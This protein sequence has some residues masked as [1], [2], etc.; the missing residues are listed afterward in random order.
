MCA[1]GSAEFRQRAFREGCFVDLTWLL[2]NRSWV[3]EDVHPQ[4]T[5]VLT[6]LA[7]KT[8]EADQVIPMR[9]PYRSLE[10]YQG[11]VAN[12][13]LRFSVA[14][15]KSWTDTC[16]LPLL[17]TEDSGEVFLQLRKAPRLDAS[18][19]GSWRARP[20]AE[21]HATI[22]KPLM[23]LT[24]ESPGEGFWPVFKGESFDI[25]QP[26]TGQYYAWANAKKV[27]TAL[28]QKRKRSARLV[29]SPFYGFPEAWNKDPATL[30]CFAPRIAFRDVSRATDTRTVRAALLPAEVFLTNKAPYFVFGSGDEKDQAY[31]LAVLC[32]LPLDWYARRFVEINLNF[33]I[34][35]PFP[36]P[37]PE[38]SH[39][40][41]LRAVELGA[42]LGAPDRRFAK[43]ARTVG[44]AHGPLDEEQ[45]LAMIA[46]LDAVVAH[47]YGLTE[48]QLGVVFETF[49]E[50]WDYSEALGATRKHFLSWKDRLHDP[51]AA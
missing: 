28:H 20:N 21:L 1:K 42:R 43:W 2:N 17:P 5:I 38:R 36:V 26:D 10:A 6:S 19:P 35:N 8:P 37:R 46:E 13:P 16:A 50:G 24:D 32:S 29:R 51:G 18:V 33:F 15:V 30:P 11:G 14:E 34:L 12:E 41:W 48:G 27:V 22:D 9:G 44:V 40:L 3:F 31:L 47:L 4:Y 23:R 25:W 49:H 7:K 39:P 45:K